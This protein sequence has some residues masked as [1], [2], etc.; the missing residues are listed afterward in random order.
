VLNDKGQQTGAD[1]VLNESKRIDGR[2]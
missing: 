2:W 1:C